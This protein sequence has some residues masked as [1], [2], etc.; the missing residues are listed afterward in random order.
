MSSLPLTGAGPSAGGW[1]PSDVSNL[2]VWLDAG[3]ITGLSDGD[4]VTTWTDLSGNSNSPTQATASKKPLYKTSIIN[5]LPVVRGDGSDDYLQVTFGAALSQP[6][7][8]FVVCK[9]VNL[10]TG[11]YRFVFDGIGVTRHAIYRKNQAAHTWWYYAGTER[12]SGDVADTSAHILVAVFN[13]A[14]S[15]LRLDGA[16]IVAT[17]PGSQTLGGITLFNDQSFALPGNIDIAECGVYDAGLSAGNIGLLETYLST[18][19][20]VSLP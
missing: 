4:A 3:T 17:D 16:E 6:N 7:T 11:D 19:Y 20:G 18:K 2:E 1:S 10:G 8:V 9:F 5:G 15:S 12:D 13:G 14:S